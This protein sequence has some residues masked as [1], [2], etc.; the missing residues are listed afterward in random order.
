MDRNNT[1]TN[2]YCLC[3]DCVL[4]SDKVKTGIKGESLCIKNGF[5]RSVGVCKDFVE[6]KEE[7]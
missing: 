2:D 4:C 5:V 3:S 7:R 1:T 6:K